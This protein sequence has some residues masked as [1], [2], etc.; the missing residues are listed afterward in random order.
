[1]L[2]ISVASAG[3]DHRLGAN[4][5]PPAIVSMFLGTE[6][7]DILDSIEKGE[8]YGTKEKNYGK[9]VYIFCHV[10]QKI[11]LIE[12]VLPH[13]HLPEINLSLEC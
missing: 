1:M 5:A 4:E 2:R 6:L 3:N 11:Q 13:L 10:F 9:L 12:T 7:T 8:Q